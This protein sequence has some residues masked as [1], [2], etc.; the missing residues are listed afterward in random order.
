M[1]DRRLW[2]TN[3]RVACESLRGSVEGV[4]FSK[5]AARRVK[6]PV[7][8]LLRAPDG[9]RD[10]QLLMGE[11][12]R[13]LEDRDGWAFVQVA[14]DGYVGY[15]RSADLHEVDAA[16]HV[17]SA[18]SSQTYVDADFKSP[19]LLALSH[20]SHIVAK[21]VGDKFVET[22]FGFIPVQHV[23]PIS[24]LSSDAIS[25]ARLYLG[26]PYLWGGNSVWGIDC[27]GLVQAACL[28]CGQPCAGDS[29][30]Q[31]E[32]LGAALALGSDFQAGDFVFWRGHVGLVTDEDSFIHANAFHMA[33]VEEPLRAAIHRIEAGGDGPLTAHRRM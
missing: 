5:G 28:A 25:V 33:V 18:R 30:L 22:E 15:V 19:D 14:K 16:T 27:S 4:P 26:A 3:E 1:T 24:E 20:G 13:V 17:V 29:D 21:S 11:E 2:P 7:A 6:R 23:K 9:K 31:S 12:A 10:R 8:D 32:S